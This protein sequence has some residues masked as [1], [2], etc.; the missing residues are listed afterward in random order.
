MVDPDFDVSVCRKILHQPEGEGYPLTIIEHVGCPSLRV[1]ELTHEV[2]LE[3]GSESIAIP[4][5]MIQTVISELVR[6]AVR[7]GGS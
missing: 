3:Q 2:V 1:V 4:P 5:E 7:I 6:A